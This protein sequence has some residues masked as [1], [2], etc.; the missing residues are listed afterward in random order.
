MKT[1]RISIWLAVLVLV[2]A[3]LACNAVTGGGDNTNS[4]STNTQ[5]TNSND[6]SSF[7]FTT[8]NIQNAHLSPDVNDS[9][10]TTTYAP[11]AKTFYCF[12]DLKNAPEDTVVKGTWTL[13]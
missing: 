5:T 2:L 7:S 8:A 4:T 13:V 9:A 1:K 12:F 6:N 11:S 3:S 10:S